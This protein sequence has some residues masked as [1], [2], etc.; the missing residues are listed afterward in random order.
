[1]RQSI[2]TFFVD[3]DYLFECKCLGWVLG[4]RNHEVMHMRLI[5]SVIGVC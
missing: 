1:M 2:Y 4:Y 5:P 3:E